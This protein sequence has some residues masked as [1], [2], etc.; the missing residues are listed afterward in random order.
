MFYVQY[1]HARICSVLRLLAEDGIRVLPYSEIDASLLT[2]PQETD[3]LKKLA[4][5]PEEVKVAAELFEPSRLTRYV[6]EVAALFHS[7]YNACRIRG[8]EKPL[9]QAR[10]KLC[11]CVRTVISNCLAALG[12]TAPEKM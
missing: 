1:A 9:A 2:A 6:L 10:L 3:L 7:F 8:E 11:D 12:V 4:E 5:L